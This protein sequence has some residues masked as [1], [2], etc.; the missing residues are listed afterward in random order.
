M[1]AIHYGPTPVAPYTRGTVLCGKDGDL[2]MS[3]NKRS[4]TCK[5][6]RKSMRA[7]WG[8]GRRNR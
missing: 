6:C 2:R 8:Y 1:K 3:T 7:S 4:V 5:T